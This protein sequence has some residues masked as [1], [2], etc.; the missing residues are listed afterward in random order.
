MKL[1]VG[2]TGKN[3]TVKYAYDELARLLK[4]MDAGLYIDL[5]VYKTADENKPGVLWLC[6]NED[7]PVTDQDEIYIHVQNGCGVIRGS[8]PPAYCVKSANAFH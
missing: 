5:H 4:A 2:T 3:P 6:A 1:I 8:N 7:A